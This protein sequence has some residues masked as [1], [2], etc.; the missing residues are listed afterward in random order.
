MSSGESARITGLPDGPDSIAWSP[1]GRRIAYLMNVPDEGLKLGAAPDKPEGANW[2]KPLQIID[3][4]TYRAD[5]AGYDF[6][7]R[8]TVV[9]LRPQ[10]DTPA[11][12][13]R[14]GCTASCETDGVFCGA[15]C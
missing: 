1:D 14:R 7:P 2:A 8:P 10:P 12:A 13:R 3:K 5:V 15:R 4:V 11:R 6:G 9:D